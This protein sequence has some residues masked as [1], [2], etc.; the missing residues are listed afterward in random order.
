MA[1]A[2]PTTFIKDEEQKWVVIGL[3]LIKELTAALRNVIATEIPKW[4]HD[5][6]QPPT[7]I[8]Q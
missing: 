6:R 7:K 4:Y 3:C 5:L 1:S 2:I 8:D